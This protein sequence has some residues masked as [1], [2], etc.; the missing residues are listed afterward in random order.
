MKQNPTR[1]I[2]F[3]FLTMALSSATTAQSW[4]LVKE[5]DGIKLYTCKEQ[6][7]SLKSFRGVAEIKA[8]LEKVFALAENI[9]NND[10]WGDNISRID[11]LQYDKNKLARYYLVYDLSWPVTD[12]DLCVDI[13]V[14]IDSL[15]GIYYIKSTSNPAAM[16]ENPDLV[17]IKEFRQSW[18]IAPGGE[19]LT[20]VILEGYA[21]PAGN[22]PDWIINMAIIDTPFHVITEVR[23]RTE[24]D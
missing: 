12:R 4:D 3:L 22:I 6:G 2:L 11:V 19:G 9:Y 5:K 17:R 18:T 13:S 14:S 21:D 23:K 7:N 15:A 16:P 24:D 8:P 20:H 1:S 10:W